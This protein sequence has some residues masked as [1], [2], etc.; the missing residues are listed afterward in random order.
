MPVVA[1]EALDARFVDKAMRDS[2]QD[3]DLPFDVLRDD[4]AD[5]RV[6][7]WFEGEE[8]DSAFYGHFLPSMAFA[9]V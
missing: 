3:D 2:G 1:Q 8:V 6:R 4:F 9:M 5:A 7:V